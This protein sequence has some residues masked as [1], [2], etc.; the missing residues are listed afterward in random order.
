MLYAWL[1]HMASSSF[2]AFAFND[3]LCFLCAADDDN[4]GHLLRWQ[5]SIT[6]YWYMLMAHQAHNIL[7]L[8]MRIDLVA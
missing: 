2:E 1:R 8:F 4:N 5:Y 6:T 7:H 3:R